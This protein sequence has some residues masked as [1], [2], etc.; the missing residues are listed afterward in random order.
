MTFLGCFMEGFQC[1][2]EDMPCFDGS[3]FTGAPT[4]SPTPAGNEQPTASPTTTSSYE[5]RGFEMTASPT[6]S[7]EAGVVTLP[8]ALVEA[9]AEEAAACVADEACQQGCIS[10]NLEVRAPAR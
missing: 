5:D 2:I 8:I 1:S 7:T 4:P 9:C 6:S 10:G 3:V